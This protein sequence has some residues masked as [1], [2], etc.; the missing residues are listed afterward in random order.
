L[1][2]NVNSFRSRLD[3]EER[4]F[5][6]FLRA[7][8]NGDHDEA[9]RV[10]RSMIERSPGVVWEYLTGYH[11]LSTGRPSEAVRL[12]SGLNPDKG[13]LKG[14]WAYRGVMAEAAHTLGDHQRE[15]ELARTERKKYPE[16]LS[17]ALYEVRALSASGR[18]EE[19]REL[20][21]A[22]RSLRPQS[23]LVPGLPPFHGLSP[24]SLMVEAGLEL[25]AH[26]KRK[27]SAEFLDQAIEW[28]KSR[29]AAEQGSEAMQRGLGEAYYAANRLADARVLF[30][31]LA[32]RYPKSIDYRGFQGAT[33]ARRGDRSEAMVAS[34]TLAEWKEPFSFG[35]NTM[36]RARIAAQLGDHESAAVLV[37]QALSEGHP[38]GIGIHRDVDLE[39]LRQLP[40]FRELLR[41][42]A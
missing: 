37:R 42:S 39:P 22:S 41:P 11:A 28:Y 25:R 30:T 8:N 26:G 10:G 19:L 20:A 12:M 38:F 27:E 29:P 36:W 35:L 34:A 17:T 21:R 4:G 15:L 6:D 18:I 33:A 1:L 2:A 7:R 9:L 5:L 13:F 24:G 23:G 3:L 16:L 14:V 32:Q 31:Q 40:R